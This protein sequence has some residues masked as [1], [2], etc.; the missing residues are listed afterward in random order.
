MANTSA[1]I[2]SLHQFLTV[3]SFTMLKGT[4]KVWQILMQILGGEIF[5]TSTL[6]EATLAFA[7]G[8]QYFWMA[9]VLA[10]WSAGVQYTSAYHIISFSS[11]A[12]NKMV[13]HANFERGV[14]CVQRMYK[15]YLT[16]CKYS[17][18][19]PSYSETKVCIDASWEITKSIH[20]KTVAISTIS[21]R[22]LISYFK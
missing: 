13:Q 17:A 6:L 20:Y 15:S 18:C 14:A 11:A 21:W 4:Q 2:C 1:H 10:A 9:P 7:D 8:I 19:N 16:A 22:S 12:C 5:R 3:S